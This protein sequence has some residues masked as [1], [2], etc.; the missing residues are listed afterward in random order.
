MPSASPTFGSG[1]STK[2]ASKTSSC[3][4]RSSRPRIRRSGASGRHHDPR[5]WLV[6]LIGLSTVMRSFSGRH[7]WL[8]ADSNRSVPVCP[9]VHVVGDVV[10]LPDPARQVDRGRCS[11]EKP[12]VATA[13]LQFEHPQAAPGGN[14]GSPPPLARTPELCRDD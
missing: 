14:G 9:Q 8:E 7:L 6:S 3:V 5:Y 10:E 11:Q 1:A 2:A 4:V 12:L 13:P